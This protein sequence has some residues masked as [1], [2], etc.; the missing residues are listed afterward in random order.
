MIWLYWMTLHDASKFPP[1]SSSCDSAY[2]GFDQN[3]NIC[4]YNGYSNF[5]FRTHGGRTHYFLI[6]YVIFG[7]ASQ[8]AFKKINSHKIPFK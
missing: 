1:I 2:Q 7:D 3:N 6:F 4:E 5:I 8:C